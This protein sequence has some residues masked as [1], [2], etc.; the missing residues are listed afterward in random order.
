MKI[1]QINDYIDDMMIMY[2]KVTVK[3]EKS[4]ISG[5]NIRIVFWT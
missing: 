5:E 1:T 2:I 4:A 3:K